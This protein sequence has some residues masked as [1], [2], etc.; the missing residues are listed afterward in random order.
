MNLLE[1]ANLELEEDA[2][3][4]RGKPAKNW[5]ARDA[6]SR[7]KFKAVASL[8][9][10][11]SAYKIAIEKFEKLKVKMTLLEEVLDRPHGYVRAPQGALRNGFDDFESCID[12]FINNKIH[13]Y[14]HMPEAYLGTE[15][16]KI[17]ENYI[18]ELVASNYDS[19]DSQNSNRH[20]MIK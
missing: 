2:R 5:R 1:K 4:T 9:I 11:E 15:V 19:S 12:L 6:L 16:F 13:F 7:E 8:N 10:A 17:K 20:G 3:K 18:F 14:S